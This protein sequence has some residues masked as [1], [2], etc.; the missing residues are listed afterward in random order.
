[1]IVKNLFLKR[2]EII[3]ANV[4]GIIGGLIYCCI[5]GFVS[6]TINENKGYEGGFW[7]GFIL[8]ILGIIVVACKSENIG[9][10][11]YS[12]SSQDKVSSYSKEIAETNMLASGGWKCVKCGRVNPSYNT[13][14][15]VCGNSKMEN[16]KIKTAEIRKDNS[17]SELQN[18]QKLKSYK[19]L[20]DIG[21]I[22]Q[23]EFDAKKK[24]LL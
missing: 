4:I 24:E 9:S 6:K 2:G 5:C 7:W 11:Y 17:T 15:C 10:S 19:E 1:M 23:E 18:I 8:G 12:T 14:S 22:S 16:E 13:G 3:V 21:A 20:L